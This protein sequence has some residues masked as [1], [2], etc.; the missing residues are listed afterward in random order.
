MNSKFLKVPTLPSISEEEFEK[1]EEII[2]VW[3][4]EESKNEIVKEE[5]PSITILNNYG[6]DITMEIFEPTISES[7]IAIGFLTGFLIFIFYFFPDHAFL[8]IFSIFVIHVYN[9]VYIF[10]YLRK[11]EMRIYIPQL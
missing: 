8:F 7:L 5:K 11:K 10:I 9:Y 6:K 2:P 4:Y 3:F 1:D